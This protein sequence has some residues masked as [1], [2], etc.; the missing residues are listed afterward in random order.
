MAA[1]ENLKIQRES[2]S[3]DG[4]LPAVDLMRLQ[5]K[6]VKNTIVDDE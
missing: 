1:L 6:A 4:G 2:H 5:V 3:S